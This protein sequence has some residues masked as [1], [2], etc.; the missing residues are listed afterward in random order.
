M[1]QVCTSQWFKK[2]PTDLAECILRPEIPSEEMHLD[3]MQSPCSP[4][5]YAKRKRTD[6]AREDSREM[7]REQVLSDMDREGMP[8]GW[9]V[10][11]GK[12][13]EGSLKILSKKKC[14]WKW[15]MDG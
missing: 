15:T 14:V 9:Q 11:T 10:Q 12:A 7:S 6:D 3:E 5:F 8:K 13:K 2:E 1:F 4:A